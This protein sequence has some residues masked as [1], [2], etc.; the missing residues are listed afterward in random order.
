MYCIALESTDPF[1]NLAIEELLLKNSMEE[2]LILGINYPSVIIGKHQSAHREVNTKF[3]IE[4]LDIETRDYVI[5]N[6]KTANGKAI[7]DLT[8]DD[9]NIIDA[10][11]SDT[12]HRPE[13]AS[14]SAFLSAEIS[15]NDADINYLSA[16]ISS[17][18][19]DIAFLSAQHDALSTSLSNVVT[20][21]VAELQNQIISNDNDINALN[22]SV[23]YLLDVD[24]KVMLYNGT[25][26]STDV[27]T[28]S[29]LTTFLDDNF[30]DVTYQFELGGMYHLSVSQ[31]LSDVNNVSKFIGANDYIIFNK[32]VIL[33]DVVFADIDLIRDAE[34]EALC[35]Q[36]ILD[37]KINK[38]SD[39]LSNNINSIKQN[40]D[41]SIGLLCSEISANDADITALDT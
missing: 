26:L 15:A 33:S 20:L 38:L 8:V 36:V 18:D 22:I 21:S 5:I 1:F 3:V 34:A 6:C 24:K 27:V 19:N 41:L 17:N 12:I 35:L 28:N 10:E 32:D 39:D 31:S 30:G 11:D 16:E 7:K 37:T 9:V 4:G 25:L 29:R 14:V 2:Y 13:L 23:S 40:I